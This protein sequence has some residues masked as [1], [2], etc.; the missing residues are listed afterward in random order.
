MFLCEQKGGSLAGRREKRFTNLVSA[1]TSVATRSRPAKP[2]DQVRGS[3][4]TA[5][6]RNA[7]RLIRL[8]TARL[9]VDATNYQQPNVAGVRVPMV[10]IVIVPQASLAWVPCGVAVTVYADGVHTVET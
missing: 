1:N 9:N 6:K 3:L 10:L 5:N 2:P 7:T 8:A 4:A